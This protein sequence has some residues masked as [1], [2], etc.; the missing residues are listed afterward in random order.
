MASPPW[1]LIIS[2]STR[3]VCAVTALRRLS[4]RRRVLIASHA[5]NTVSLTA[6]VGIISDGT[7]LQM[8]SRAVRSSRK[9]PSPNSIM[10]QRSRA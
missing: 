8:A 7:A 2:Y 3:N 5:S 6:S 1:S 4:P 10:S 9:L